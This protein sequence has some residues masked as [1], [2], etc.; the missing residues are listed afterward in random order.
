MDHS[1]MAEAL[2]VMMKTVEE[3]NMALRLKTNQDQLIYS[4]LDQKAKTQ[5]C[6]H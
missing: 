4:E 5:N 2:F 3:D 1:N 6:Q